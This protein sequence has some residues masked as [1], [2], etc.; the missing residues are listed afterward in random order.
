MCSKEGDFYDH[1]KDWFVNISYAYVL[2]YKYS[3]KLTK[4]QWM[5]VI[6]ITV[7]ILVMQSFYIGAQ[8]RWY[9]KFDQM[10]SLSWLGGL[11]KT[12]KDAE[13]VLSV[14]KYFG[15]CTFILYIIGLTLYLEYKK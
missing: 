4:P 6:G 11:V 12:K 7:F 14:A 13:K 9:G 2:Y 8:E 5:V 1:V 10:P 15:C 3:H